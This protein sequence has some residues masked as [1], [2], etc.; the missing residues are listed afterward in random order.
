MKTKIDRTF[1]V[2][3]PIEKVW[4]FLSDP[5]KVVTCVPGAQITEK[6]DDKNYKGQVSMKFGPVSTKYNGEITIEELNVENYNMILKGK[7]LDAKGKGSA[8]MEMTGTLTE[9][10]SGTEVKYS[11]EVS[12]TGMLAQFGSRLITDVSNQL[13]NQFINSFKQKLSGEEGEASAGGNS[14]NAASMMGS[15][16]KD[17]VSGLFK[18]KKSQEEEEKDT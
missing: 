5:E 11:M 6:V 4:S 16:I 3:E 7:G 1:M 18:G 10:D 15:M 12:V 13:T 9:K 8:D 14:L 2:E 17:K